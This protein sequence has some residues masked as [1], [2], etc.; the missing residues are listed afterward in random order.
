M[1]LLAA[2]ILIPLI[3]IGL[4]IQ[5]G[6]AIG[7]W[8]TLG[9]VL[10]T[11]VVGSY[12]VRSQGLMALGSLRQS[13]GEFSDPTEPLANGAMILFAGALLLTPGFFTDAIGFSLLLPPVR[14]YVFIKVKDRVA[15]N[16]T[17]ASFHASSF[18]DPD[19]S[20]QGET[21]DVDF[22]E[23]S[24]PSESRGGNSGWTRH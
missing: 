24:T 17:T 7:L 4:F 20:R 13:I 16:V 12:L 23:I 10:M 14:R 3:E 19:A 1:W 18:N 15:A 22:E 8:P 2:F 5:V 9:I 21:I 11:A 6:G